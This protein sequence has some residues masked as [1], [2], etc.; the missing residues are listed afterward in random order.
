[1]EICI[2]V[3]VQIYILI[4]P[5]FNTLGVELLGNIVTFIFNIFKNYETLFPS[6]CTI[7]YFHLKH[8]HV[9]IPLPSC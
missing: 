4:S 2:H 6:V 3:F 9:P 7:L 5:G 8:I 1:M